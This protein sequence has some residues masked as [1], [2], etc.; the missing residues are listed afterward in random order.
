MQFQYNLVI[1]SMMMILKFWIFVLFC[2]SVWLIS[3]FV[4]V[5]SLVG[6]LILLVQVDKPKLIYSMFFW[7]FQN[8]IAK[9]HCIYSIISEKQK[10]IKQMTSPTNEFRLSF[11]N[12]HT[13]NTYNPP[14]SCSI[15]IIIVGWWFVLILETCR[16]WL[17][18]LLTTSIHLQTHQTHQPNNL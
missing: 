15:I 1:N 4:C 9:K 2:F 3:Y 12:Q 6:R 14:N 5:F 11:Y 7:D 8:R 17:L 18:L 16:L 13:F 10:I